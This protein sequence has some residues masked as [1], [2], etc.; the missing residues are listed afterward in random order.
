MQSPAD[1][2]GGRRGAAR[3]ELVRQQMLPLL[4]LLLLGR[5]VAASPPPPTPASLPLAWSAGFSSDMVL[6]ATSSSGVAVYGLATG[7]PA[8]VQVTVTVTPAAGGQPY[9]CTANVT[10][11]TGGSGWEWRAVLRPAAAGHGQYTIAARCS[12]CAATTTTTTTMHCGRQG[13]RGC[14]G[15]ARARCVR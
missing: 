8:G 1:R 2:S 3:Y 15:R 5:R 10:P 13:C 11:S 7:P 6:Q 12:G 14:R 4:L 9:T